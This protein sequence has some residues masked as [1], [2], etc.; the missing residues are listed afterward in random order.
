MLNILYATDGS[1]SAQSAAHFLAHLPRP[2]EVRLHLLTVRPLDERGSTSHNEG[3]RILA[4]ARASLTTFTG[5]IDSTIQYV[6]K[7]TARIVETIAKT[8]KDKSADLIALGFCGRSALSRFFVGSVAG[9]V[10]HGAPCPVL[11]A[12]P[13]VGE[14]FDC[15]LV[16]FDGSPDAV[17]AAD[18][19]P[20]LPLSDDC[21]IH[22]LSVVL[23]P[24][25]FRGGAGILLKASGAGVDNLVD[26][27]R[28]R[29]S[30]AQTAMIG[31]LKERGITARI[32]PSLLENRDAASCL[33]AAARTD[34]VDLI[35]VGSQGT[36]G[37][38]DV[39]LG[40]VSDHILYH[41]PCSVLIVRSGH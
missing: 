31:K 25:V 22:V 41:S 28:K 32:I 17:T 3:E 38:E 34:K 23:P 5:S 39:F 8:A 2:E 36:T 33:V 4:E 37:A 15:I 29:I 6:E 13:V 19:L 20:N 1:Q 21:V 12:G 40:S 26:R 30:A 18:W 7:G 10:A 9:G 24:P 14:R 27:D 35:V 11:L 16:G